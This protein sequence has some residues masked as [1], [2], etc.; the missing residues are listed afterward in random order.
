MH[1]LLLQESRGSDE[2]KGGKQEAIKRARR[3]YISK[4]FVISIKRRNPYRI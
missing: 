4:T 3:R 2:D 1:F